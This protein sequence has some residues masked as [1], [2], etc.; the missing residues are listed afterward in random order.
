VVSDVVQ[1]SVPEEYQQS[2][3]GLIPIDWEVKALGELVSSV[4][5]GSSAKSS[6]SGAVP[7]LRMGNLQSGKIDWDGLVYTSDL[8]EI[9][10]YKLKK[11]DVLFNRTNTVDLVGKTSIYKGEYPAV[12]AGYLIRIHRIEHLLDADFLNYTL[13]SYHSKKYSKFIL[14]V[15][16]SQANING[17]K[18]KTYPI[19]TPPSKEEQT[20]IAKVLSDVDALITSL[21]KLI[22]KKRAIKTASMQQLLTGKKR[23]PPFD[24]T[25]TGYKQTELG[26]IPEDW[27]VVDIESIASKVG[28][29]KTPKG[30]STVYKNSGRP[31]VRSQNVGWG[32]LLLD[33]VAYISEEVHETFLGSELRERDVLLNI[34]GAS[35]GR[36]ASANKELLGGN[37]NQ[38]VCLIRVDHKK[39][40]SRIIASLILSSEGQRQIDSFQ[41]G[42]NREGL[43]FTQV[44]ALQFTLSDCKE[45]QTAIADVLS[46]MD[47]EVEKL[48][49]RLSKTQ[50][51][52]QGMMQE[53]LTGRTRLL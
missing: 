33:D 26:G 24:Q 1:Q 21:E 28:S 35:I 30:G 38:H 14:S 42:G 39:V 53:L 15:A 43:N 41:A 10:K 13:N 45:E 18:L 31:L 40:D 6:E 7:V 22:A 50:Q 48:S 46:D 32:K 11:D 51:F 34:T 17:Q 3:V 4:E 27:E 19:P 20:A 12:F 16:V 49:Q 25:H 44:K 5:Y 52:K 37:V 9:A 23:L 8:V 29:G 36:C 47:V 2:D